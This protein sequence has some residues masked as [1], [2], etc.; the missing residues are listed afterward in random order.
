MRWGRSLALIGLFGGCRCD[1]GRDAVATPDASI[2]A[3]VETEAEPPPFFRVL[4]GPGNIPRAADVS[5]ALVAFGRDADGPLVAAAIPQR[6]FCLQGYE[7]F[8]VDAPPTAGVIEYRFVMAAFRENGRVP[9]AVVAS[10]KKTTTLG[11]GS[12]FLSRTTSDG[13]VDAGGLRSNLGADDAWADRERFA[14]RA[15]EEIAVALEVVEEHED[16]TTRADVRCSTLPRSNRHFVRPTPDETPP[17]PS[18]MQGVTT[19]VDRGDDALLRHLSSDADALY[20][21]ETREHD[22]GETKLGA[23]MRVPK[24]GGEAVVVAKDQSDAGGVRTDATDAYWLVDGAIVRAPKVGGGAVRTIA[25]AKD[26]SEYSTWALDGDDLFFAESTGPTGSVLRRVARDGGA[27]MTVA[28]LTGRVID[29][30]V[31][32]DVIYLTLAPP[33]E[34]AKS[35]VSVPRTGGAPRTLLEVSDHAISHLVASDCCF[36]WTAGSART[37]YRM[38]KTEAIPTV[39]AQV[40]FG[41]DDELGLVERVVLHD[42]ELYLFHF[43]PS[44][45]TKVP[46]GGGTRIRGF[47]LVRTMTGVVS[48]SFEVDAANVYFQAGRKLARFAR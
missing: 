28:N 44:K 41:T 35:L 43:S 42:D 47:S 23:V 32:H 2:L 13:G 40:K 30:I 46:T 17:T 29:L 20:W 11:R 15:M 19:I 4:D 39:L 6:R 3:R 10:E 48:T 26:L 38:K 27:T 18:D 34:M 5:E 36:Y 7:V 8:F 14:R 37:V 12:H 22:G 24:A 1:K 45:I 21:T 9:L 33:R 16:V 31:D 25:R